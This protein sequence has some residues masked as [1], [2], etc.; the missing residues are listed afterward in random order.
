MVKLNKI[1]NIFQ[2][3]ALGMPIV[4]AYTASNG[5]VGAF[6]DRLKAWYFSIQPD[7]SIRIEDLLRGWGPYILSVL[8]ISGIKVI[9]KFTNGLMKM[10]S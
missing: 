7:G 8:V 9:P 4:S 6:I 3:V 5:D 1:F 10:L 2:L